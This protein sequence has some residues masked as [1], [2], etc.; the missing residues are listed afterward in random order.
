LRYPI[1]LGNDC[2]N[3]EETIGEDAMNEV[4]LQNIPID[5]T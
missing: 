4:L 3:C 1:S 2:V 5:L